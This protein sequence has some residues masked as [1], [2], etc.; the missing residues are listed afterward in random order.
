[1]RYGTIGMAD[2]KHKEFM[3]NY[4][5]VREEIYGKIKQSTGYNRNH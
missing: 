3:S 5:E 1:M 4:I 2:I